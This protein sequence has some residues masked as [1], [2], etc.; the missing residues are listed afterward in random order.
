M[1]GCPGTQH[2]GFV[3]IASLVWDLSL[4]ALGR[5]GT[6]SV[7]GLMVTFRGYAYDPVERLKVQ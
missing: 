7:S 5:R 1:M 4:V 2:V 3:S 6:T